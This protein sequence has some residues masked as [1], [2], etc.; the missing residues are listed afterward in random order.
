MIEPTIEKVYKF[1]NYPGKY[2]VVNVTIDKIEAINVSDILN[3][4][5]WKVETFDRDKIKGFVSHGRNKDAYTKYMRY[6]T[7]DETFE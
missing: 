7:G 2:M 4:D 6:V 1:H 3:S 5:K